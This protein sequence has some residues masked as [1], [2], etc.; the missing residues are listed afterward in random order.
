MSLKIGNFE[1][2]ILAWDFLS[3]KS[4]CYLLTHNICY[5]L[6]KNVDMSTLLC[7]C[8]KHG[9]ETAA[10]SCVLAVIQ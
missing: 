3:M 5:K 8:T 1:A 2:K 6:L 4:E 10:D 9:E 7:R